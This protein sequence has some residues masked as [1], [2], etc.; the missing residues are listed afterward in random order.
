MSSGQQRMWFVNRL[1]N[2]GAAY[3]MAMAVRLVG[4]LRTAALEAAWADVVG[5]H[6]ALRT[7]FAEADGEVRQRVRDEPPA[8]LGNRGV[9]EEELAS[10]LAAEA[11]REFD[12]RAEP[13]CRATLY[14]LS[15]RE[16]VLLLVVHHIA[17]DGRSLEVLARDL[18]RAYAARSRGRAPEWTP[19]P[20][21]YTDV[22]RR[23]QELLGAG[24]DPESVYGRQLAYWRQAL[25]GLPA[26]LDLPC[27]RPRPAEP[28][29]EGSAVPVR[30]P[31]DTHRALLRIADDCDA[32]PLMVV[33]A[34]LAVLL[35]RLGAG[36]DIPIGSPVDGRT[37]ATLEDLVGFVANT[38]VLRTDLTSGRST[39][40][41][42]TRSRTRLPRTRTPRAAHPKE[43]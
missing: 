15:P 40:R 31:P 3:T 9:S 19:L 22:A 26:Q 39:N 23:Q 1:E 14:A 6:E 33:R 25:A 2:A 43:S 17:V 12:L 10:V 20:V 28:R 18:S 5:R 32:T 16:H 11:G 7:V 42:A 8:G 36:D 13:P 4:G 24:Q 27:D 38:L 35:S 34:A 30:I 37:D 21:A 29:H 41:G